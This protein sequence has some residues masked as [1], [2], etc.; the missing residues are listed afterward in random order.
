M[1][2]SVHGPSQRETDGEVIQARRGTPPRAS[3]RCRPEAVRP[4]T[5]ARL[6]PAARLVVASI[7]DGDR[8]TESLL[9]SEVMLVLT[10]AL[11]VGVRP[12]ARV[13]VF[14]GVTVRWRSPST[15]PYIA[16]RS[17]CPQPTQGRYV[18]NAPPRVSAAAAAAAT[19]AADAF[20]ERHACDRQ[21]GEGVCPPP[22]EHRVGTQAGEQCDG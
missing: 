12:V 3:L 20:A 9:V 6:T 1:L 14:E 5:T 17:P 15:R 10:G 2:P 8:A 13:C 7:P 11:D 18:G 19:P 21:R 4:T 16:A 22:A